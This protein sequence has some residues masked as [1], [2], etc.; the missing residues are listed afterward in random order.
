MELEIKNKAKYLRLT[1]EGDRYET[2][3]SSL[4][5]TRE[6]GLIHIKFDKLEVDTSSDKY[7]I[8]VEQLYQK[9]LGTLKHR[10]HWIKLVPHE[11]LINLHT[12]IEVYALPDEDLTGRVTFYGG[13]I[14]INE[15]CAKAA[16]EKDK[17]EYQVQ[18]PTPNINPLNTL[19]PWW[20]FW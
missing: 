2:I 3:S 7:T 10:Y 12:Q 8:K 14:F 9:N 18:T 5:I 17:E 4:S 20:K 6:D 11:K 13:H 16:W 1:I 15:E 19:K